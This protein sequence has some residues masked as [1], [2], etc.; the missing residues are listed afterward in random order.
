V[1]EVLGLVEKPKPA[2][3]PSRLAAVGR[4]IL[5]PEIM[6]LLGRQERARAARSS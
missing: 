6:D 5:Q 4:Y 1:T 3:A 2:D